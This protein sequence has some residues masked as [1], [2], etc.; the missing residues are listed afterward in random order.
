MSRRGS[1]MVGGKAAVEAGAVTC[2]AVRCS[3][4]LGVAVECIGAVKLRAAA[5]GNEDA[6]RSRNTIVV[7][8]GALD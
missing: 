5:Q 2:G 3:A 8:L 1:C 4:C 7:A 6:L